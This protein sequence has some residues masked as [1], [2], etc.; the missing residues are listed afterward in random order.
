MLLLGEYR[1][2]KRQLG[3]SYAVFDLPQLYT[4][5]SAADILKALGLLAV[6]PRT[7]S[8]DQKLEVQ[9]QI[10]ASG[11]SQYLTSIIASALAWVDSDEL[12]EQIWEAAS[13]RLCERSGRSGKRRYYGRSELERETET[14][15]IISN[16]GNV[17]SIYGSNDAEQGFPGDTPR[18]VY[19]G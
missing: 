17:K 8:N 7:F 16:A 4:K 2:T 14:H 6:Q 18:T 11:I 1:L 3:L 5:P 12:R 10:H 15:L 9:H 19:Y 13:A